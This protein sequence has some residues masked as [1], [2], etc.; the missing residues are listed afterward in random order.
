LVSTPSGP[1]RGR[2]RRQDPILVSR[3]RYQRLAALGLRIGYL[4]L[5]LAVVAFLIGA[6][7]GFASAAVTVT[8]VGLVGACVI[9][10][11]AIIADYAVKA[12]E[13]DDRQ[14]GRL[15]GQSR[16]GDSDTVN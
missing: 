5:G 9:L 12:A 16:S 14:A 3:D 8:I 7:S 2:E 11:P 1:E 10:P 15:P 13:R 6:V 4:L